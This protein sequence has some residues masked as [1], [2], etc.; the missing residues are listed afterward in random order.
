MPLN[1]ARA[2]GTDHTESTS[3]ASPRSD[4][5]ILTK[6]KGRNS[7]PLSSGELNGGKRSHAL[8]YPCRSARTSHPRRLRIA[9]DRWFAGSFVHATGTP[10]C[11]LSAGT[12]L[13]ISGQ[14]PVL[15]LW[16]VHGYRIRYIRLLRHQS[17]LR[18]RA[19][20][21][22]IALNV[23]QICWYGKRRVWLLLPFVHLFWAGT[24]FLGCRPSP[25]DPQSPVL[26]RHRQ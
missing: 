15:D 8:P 4:P 10:G 1:F 23:N 25:A 3:G 24:P 14:L 17:D 9:F 2:P 26:L 21:K 5:A 22:T 6:I 16:P 19:A 11:L 18:F 12:Q 13:G 7:D 20:R